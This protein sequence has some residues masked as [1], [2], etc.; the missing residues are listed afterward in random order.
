M[1]QVFISYSHKDREFVNRL[2][3][4]LG[5]RL[6]DTRVFYDM[7]IQPGAS[8]A[9]TLT[10]QIEQADIVLA[11]LSPDYLASGWAEQEL[12]IA[13][14]RQLKKQA[15]LLPVLVRPCNPTGFLSQLTWVDFTENYEVGLAR[16]IW[17]I[18]GERPK[19]AKGE[20]P[21]APTR[22]IAPGEVENLRREIQAAVE[23]FKSRSTATTPVA[24]PAERAERPPEEKRRC[25]VVM[26]F[27][28]QDL[29]VVYDDFVKPTLVDGCNLHCERGDDVFGSN[30]IMEDILNSISAADV[31]LADLTRKNANV[32]YEVGIC[33]ALGKPV[34]LLAQSID[35]VPFDLRHRRVLLY[36]YSPRGCKR[37][38]GTLRQN[39]NAVLK[40][41]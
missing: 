15:R 33:H 24:Q 4:D 1:S 31:I 10:A 41:L 11:V 37:L 34:L 20:E 30:V 7:L 39:M 8:W 17:G 35:D 18:T 28:D 36:D 16:L 2:T 27:G 6:P 23:L 12:N 22:A 14:E 5:A 40:G 21:G 13:L 25:F 29:Q 9:E 3:T 38:E 26:P 19:A 32:F